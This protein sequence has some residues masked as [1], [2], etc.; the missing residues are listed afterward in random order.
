MRARFDSRPLLSRRNYT[1]AL[2][3][4]MPGHNRHHRVHAAHL[5][6]VIVTS[7]VARNVA[8][9]ELLDAIGPG[10]LGQAYACEDKTRDQTH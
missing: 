9:Q 7:V 3:A 2:A 4:Q 8:N 1:T 6:C 10:V 5:L